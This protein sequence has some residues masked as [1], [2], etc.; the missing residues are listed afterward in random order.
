MRAF[1]LTVWFGVVGVL[2][3][4][5]IG[6]DPAREVTAPPAPAPVMATPLAPLLPQAG[7]LDEQVIVQVR[8]PQDGIGTAFAVNS[9]GDWLTARHVV[10]G[11]SKVTIEVAPDNFVP[12]AS[13]VLDDAHDLALLK[14]GRSPDPVRLNLKAPL[15]AGEEGYLVGFPQGEPGEVAA[16]LTA[17]ARLVTRG[18]R[19]G[20]A[21]ILGWSE[22]ERTQGLKG[23]LGGLSGGPVF[24][25]GGAVRGVIVAESP[26]RGRIYTAGPDA[27]AAFLAVAGVTPEA[28]LAETFRLTAFGTPS[29]N[30]RR[31]L[32]VV[33]VVCE[34][35]A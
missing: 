8:A 3:V 4:V 20:N 15:R 19:L 30:A 1:D 11:C 35:A 7:P 23:A 17:R 29:D 5:L 2:L 9:D 24:D 12:V 18:G 27:I 28:G 31:R 33:K 22:I 25:T 21:E 34:V 32:Q 13:L 26:R 6:L 16:R 10:D 14:T